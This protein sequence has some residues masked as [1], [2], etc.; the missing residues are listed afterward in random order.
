MVAVKLFS[1]NNLTQEELAQATGVSQA[2]IAYA[3]G[4]VEHAPGL[5]AGVIA[6]ASLNDAYDEAIKR[7]KADESEE[8]QLTNL[9]TRYPD[10]ADKVVEDELTP[11]GAR[12]EAAAR[13]ERESELRDLIARSIEDAMRPAGERTGSPCSRRGRKALA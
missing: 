8:T 5:V 1:K 4:V 2:R 9:R 7:K 11:E 10:L 12:A 13:D 3:R 6:G